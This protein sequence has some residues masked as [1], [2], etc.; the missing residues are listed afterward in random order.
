M[1]QERIGN[2]VHLLILCI[3]VI[4]PFSVWLACQEARENSIL[5][6]VCTVESILLL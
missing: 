1:N 3:L 4:P 5:L 2:R 6:V